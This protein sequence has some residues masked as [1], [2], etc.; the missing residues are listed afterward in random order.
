M[1]LWKSIGGM[2][3]MELT[4]ACVEEV[5]AAI[6]EKNISIFRVETKG[7]LT[8]RFQIER[9]NHAA[10][11]RL[12]EKRGETLKCV[13]KKGLY[14]EAKRMAMRPVLAIGLVFLMISAL[15]IPR[16]VFFVQVEGSQ[17]VPVN[18]ILEAAAE[19]GISFGASRKEVR[20]ERVKNALL[21]KVPQLQWAGVNTRGCV[22]VITV[23]ERSVHQQIDDYQTVSSIVA[24]RD[25]V[26]ESCTATR[27]S[28]V[29][30][31]GQ[32]V[33]AG[34]VLISGYTDCGLSI[35][36]T[37]AEGEVYA[38]TVR[39]L[40]AVYPRNWIAKGT[41]TKRACQISLLI[42]KKRINLWKD[43]GI[44]DTTCGRMY[45]EYYVTLPGGFALPVA[46]C[47]DTYS[48]YEPVRVMADKSDATL[49]FSDFA[50]RSLL[51]QMVAGEILS[52]E[53]LVTEDE[54]R[55]LLQGSYV[56]REMIGRVHF[57]KMGD[58]Y[59]KTD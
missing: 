5:L 58:N 47:V 24:N 56:C 57:E 26:V 37:R 55:Y 16:Y 50:Q 41:E 15:V 23:R 17:N 25:G 38:Q 39:P 59:G 4:S 48:F 19:C 7:D 29:C 3:E 6:S 22:A 14:W 13:G 51:D 46:L 8:L 1:N 31:P 20:S 2:L 43:S 44:W 42:G 49:L 36:A 28:L 34:E 21:S 30:A 33:K 32:A 40:Q 9:K 35:Q 53:E 54:F 11:R 18:Q 27:G 12:C 52:R 45:K 10:L